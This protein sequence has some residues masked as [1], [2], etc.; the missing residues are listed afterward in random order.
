MVVLWPV[1]ELRLSINGGKRMKKGFLCAGILLLMLIGCATSPGVSGVGGERAPAE[2]ETSATP[3]FYGKAYSK[4]ALEALNASKTQAVRK[5]VNLLLGQASAAVHSDELNDIFSSNINAY[6]YGG[7]LVIIQEGKDKDGHYYEIGVRVDLKAAAGVMKAHDIFGGQVTPGA[8]DLYALTDEP[9]PTGMETQED[10]TVETPAA[11]SKPLPPVVAVSPEEQQKIDEFVGNMTWMVYYNEETEEDPFVMKAAVGSANKYLAG[12]GY[13]YIDLR[14]IE[15][16]KQDQELAYEEETGQLV[17][18]I[19]WIASRLNADIYIEISAATN[20]KIDGN[21]Y[22]G[23]ASV[24]LNNYEAS[25]AEGRGSATY[26]TIPPA[27]STVSTDDAVYNA[28]TSAVYQIMPAAIQQAVQYTKKALTRGIRFDLILYNTSDA[29]LMRD[30]KRNM[31]RRVKSIETISQ[32]AE[33]TRYVVRIIGDIEDLQDIVYDVADT[34]PGLQR[35][36][37]VYLRGKSITFDTGL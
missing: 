7:S 18:I 4:S 32:S 12:Q 29:R 19:Q 30:F 23:S 5:A 26:T 20:A 2:T 37:L 15:S 17:S 11:T 6:I 14:Q 3:M 34:L 22:Y 35:M 16:I 8:S 10:T 24:V 1:W 21:N 9:L 36:D 27:F 28:I 31:E 25:T 13:D 33:E